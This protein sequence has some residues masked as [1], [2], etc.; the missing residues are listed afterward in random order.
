MKLAL[1]GYTD[2]YN[3]RQW[4]AMAGD[5]VARNDPALASAWPNAAREIFDLRGANGRNFLDDRGEYDAVVLFAI[6][7]PPA[8]D[9]TALRRALRQ[10]GQQ[11]L[12][13]NHSRD[14][15]A[16]RLA[17]TDAKYLFVFRRPDSVDGRWLGAIDGY[18]KDPETLG[19]F[20]LSVYR[21]R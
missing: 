6:Y 9:P 12:P 19:V 16:A 21:R 5:W 15:W 13:P 7:N 20:G 2:S 18:E 17:R 10:R 14:N 8:G 3:D 4:Q 11:S 1:V